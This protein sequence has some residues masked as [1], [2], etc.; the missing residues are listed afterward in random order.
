MGSG[1]EAGQRLV[2]SDLSRGMFPSLA[3][4]QIPPGGAFDITNGL[5][6][7]SNVVYRR[8]GA[9][10]ADQTPRGD[11]R[12]LW[13]GYLRHGGQQTLLGTDTGVY[14]NGV[15]VMPAGTLSA[16]TRAQVLEGV[17]YLPGGHTYDGETPGTI[18]PAAP[19]YATAGGRLLAGEGS[20]VSFSHVP[21]HEN[22]A[23]T[24]DA[25]DFHQ[26]PGGVQ[27]I[28]MEGLRTSCVVFTTE[29]I[30]VI[31]NLERELT[32]A[33]GNVQQTL[34]RYSADAVLWG[35]A[36]IAGWSGGLVVP[37]RDNIWL[38]ELGVSSEKAAP[39]V[40]ISD[41]IQNVY[42][43]YV[44]AGYT[45]GLAAVHRG[46]YFLP[47]LKG[48]SVIDVLVC[49]LDATG[50]RGR[51]TF[52]WAH[53]TGAGALLPA[54]AITDE[55]AAFL[56]A[57]AGLGRLLRLGYFEPGSVYA[58]DAGT[59]I[60]FSVTYRDILTGNLVRNLVAKA[61]L[62]YQMSGGP[63]AKLAMSFGST[64]FAGTF[65]D[66]FNWDEADWSEAGGPFTT[67]E[68]TA[69]ADHEALNPH[70]WRV[71]R[72]VRFARVKVTLEGNPSKLS[73]RALELFVRLDGRLI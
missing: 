38:M 24:W 20:R 43:G 18:T 36:G 45:P 35:D 16:L 5:L 41:P 17:L 15:Q 6:D 62:S 9:L 50:A 66:E 71:T 51:R 40:H 42:R 56:G 72:K 73:L 8:G 4:E 48:S 11:P 54:F 1:F 61:R 21:E 2:E 52:P 65:W 39:F 37:C 30:W 44:A 33:E 67:L 3:P 26:L 25:T 14:R 70:T 29:G 63:D 46:H 32:D 59:P 28:G 55:D 49:R 27:I 57:T 22:D 34:D 69:P 47:I 53:L 64:P 13:S 23:L 19:H 10:Y 31:G 7:E 58:T 12:L 60:A 68:G